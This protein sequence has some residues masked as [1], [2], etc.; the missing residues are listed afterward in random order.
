M[1]VLTLFVGF[2]VGFLLAQL[3]AARSLLRCR[4]REE[5]A[6]ESLRHANERLAALSAQAAEKPLKHRTM[7]DGVK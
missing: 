1:D 4:Q 7:W 6:L 2:S 3:L 5:D